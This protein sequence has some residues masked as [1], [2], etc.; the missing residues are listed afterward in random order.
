M[1]TRQP[2]SYL[3]RKADGTSSRDAEIYEPPLSVGS[4][5]ASEMSKYRR[6]VVQN[7][8]W[9]NDQQKQFCKDA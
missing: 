1:C 3:E 5:R 9:V 6:E 8:I 7:K 2:G 4:L